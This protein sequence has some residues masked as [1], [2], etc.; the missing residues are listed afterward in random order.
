[1]SRIAKAFETAAKEKRK[2]LVAYIC[3]GDP[4]LEA[5]AK[6]VPAIVEAGAD[7]IELGIPFSDPIA[8][9]PTIQ[10]ASQRALANGT[11]LG[12]VLELVAQVRA[13]GC[14][15]PLVLMGYLNPI[16]AMGAEAFCARAAKAGVDGLIIP[17]LPYDEA[18]E[19]SGAAEKHGLDLILL[20]APTTLPERLAEI[21]RRT[22][23]FL[24]FVS[25][26][27][28][29]G[30]RVELPK[31]L[32][33]RLASLKRITQAPVAVGFGIST[34]EQARALSEYADAVVVGSA[35]VKAVEAA[36]GDT[37]P[38]A[39]LVRSLAEALRI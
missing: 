35:I 34:P 30:A 1:V 13:Q 27:G 28:V 11:T 14:E 9:G 4:S 18:N 24:Y 19:L 6:L 22:R 20:A 16:T 39:T 36:K 5:T 23:G 10:A 29:T 37:A 38:V 15:V 3:A 33:E 26:T 8:D 31:D 25:V 2:S 32:P 17:D 12:K 21:G 7:V